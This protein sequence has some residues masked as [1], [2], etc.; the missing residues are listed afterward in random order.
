M[1]IPRFTDLRFTNL[2]LGR[3][4]TS[5]THP[6]PRSQGFPQRGSFRKKLF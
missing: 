1:L 3:A 5:G 4:R 6:R 2:L